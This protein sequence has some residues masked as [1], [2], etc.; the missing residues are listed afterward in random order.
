MTYSKACSKC[1][2]IQTAEQ[3][4]LDKR[5][6]DGLRSQC[7]I[8]IKQYE[9]DRFE[10]NPDAVR[11]IKN[12][13][14]INRYYKDHEASKQKHRVEE[15]NRRA[16]NPEAVRATESIYR[17]KNRDKVRAKNRKSY[18]I[19]KK[20]L[21]F[22]QRVDYQVNE[23]RQAKAILSSLKLRAMK[24]Q[25]AIYEVSIQEIINLRKQTCLIC[26]S[27]SRVE[28][29]HIIPLDRGGSHSIGNFQPLCPSCNRSKGT[30]VMTEWRKQMRIDENF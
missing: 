8:C 6:T 20:S 14:A 5:S 3:F 11:A 17:N 30:K 29:D 10:K 1:K 18:R 13:S 28:I 25:N 2:Q 15:R 19:H 27:A 16:K 23:R 26:D 7:K 22:R 9:A 12:K 4:Y 21:L 24:A